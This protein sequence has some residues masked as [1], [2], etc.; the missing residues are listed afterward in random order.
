MKRWYQLTY[1][2]PIGE[3]L[4]VIIQEDKL[5]RICNIHTPMFRSQ[6]LSKFQGRQVYNILEFIDAEIRELIKFSTL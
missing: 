2:L 4:E 3:S 6:L 5:G 1:K